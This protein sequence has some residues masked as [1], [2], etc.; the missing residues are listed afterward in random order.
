MREKLYI[1]KVGGNVIEDEAKI[2]VFLSQFHLL[3]GK[4]I[5]IH[6]GGK[7]ASNIADQLGEK[8]VMVQGRRITD[9]AM[10]KIVT[11]VYGGLVNKNI[12]AKLQALGTNAFGL[13]GA[14]GNLI[15]AKRRPPKDGV[16]FG[17][18]GDVTAVNHA[19]LLNLLNA[20]LTP[21]ISPLTHDGMG[22]ILNTNADTIASEVSKSLA[23]TFDVSLVY[24]FELKGV[25]ADIDDET[26]LIKSIQKE[27]LEALIA[28]GKIHS[29]MIPKL[30]N[31]F[32]SIEN[33]VA[34]VRIC[35]YDS[36]HKLGQEEFN[37][38]TKI[39]A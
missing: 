35:H 26:S 39:I 32:E 14:D 8:V 4:K 10:I 3:V 29:G 1:I 25:M 18:V 22:N 31:A 5:L 20:T 16:D 34:D 36:I 19:L 28:S 33:G 30:E 17:N 6:G 21:I 13:S 12:T 9:D 38:Y 27:S 23:T 24:A 7:L 2:D 37:D 11:M 15:E